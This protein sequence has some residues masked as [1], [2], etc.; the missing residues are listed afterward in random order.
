LVA[1]LLL[2]AIGDS[3]KL[4]DNIEFIVILDLSE[5]KAAQSVMMVEEGRRMEMVGRRFRR[6]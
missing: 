4:I 6:R 5:I 1:C 3:S 2:I